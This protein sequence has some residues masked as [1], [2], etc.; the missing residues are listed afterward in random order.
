MSVLLPAPFSPMKAC[1]S[2]GQM[3][4]PTLLRT[5]TPGKLLQIWRNSRIGRSLLLGP[6]FVL[7]DIVFGDQFNRNEGEFLS[8]LFTIHNIVTNVD[9]FARHRV[10]ILCRTSHDQAVL[11]F[12]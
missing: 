1:T 8:R 6:A 3:L 5:R 10:R 4:S 2:P 12:E 9:R 7:V 11:I